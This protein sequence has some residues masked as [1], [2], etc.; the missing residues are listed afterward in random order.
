MASDNSFNEDLS[1]IVRLLTA[2]LNEDPEARNDPDLIASVQS[3]LGS[4]WQPRSS[5]NKENNMNH[6][7]EP[8]D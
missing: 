5:N 2:E 1:A 7:R 4:T 3:D 8:R 6:E